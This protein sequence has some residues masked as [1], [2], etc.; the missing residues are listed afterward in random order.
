MFTADKCF[1]EIHLFVCC[2]LQSDDII[3]SNFKNNTTLVCRDGNNGR[4]LVITDQFCQPKIKYNNNNI[5][6]E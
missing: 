2:Y 3:N 4:W 1:S 5:L 6:L